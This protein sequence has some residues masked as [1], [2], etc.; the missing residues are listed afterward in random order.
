VYRAGG[1]R[2][3]T[4]GALVTLAA[5]AIAGG[6]AFAYLVARRYGTPFVVAKKIGIGGLVFI[7]GRLAI[8][9]VHESAHALAMASYG[10]RVSAAGLKLVLVFPYAFVDTSDVWFESR[11]HRIA[12]TAAGPASDFALGGLF[13]LIAFALAPGT[14]RDVVFQLAFAAYVGAV[15]NLNPFLDRDG[16]QILVDVLRRPRLR[17]AAAE[18]LKRRL[19]GGEAGPDSALL[20][21]Y[22]AFRVGWLGLA[23][24]YSVAMSLHY[25]ARFAALVPT[26]VA[27]T[28]MAVLWVAFF[29]PVAVAAMP[30]WRARR[31]GGSG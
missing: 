28:A 13:S 4:R 25:Q 8:A 19:S 6:M 21:R 17:K 23:G 29:A 15:F 14:L 9:A 20:A 30:L 2:L 18:E 24:L 27:W 26:P 31:L 22:S 11:R 3:F 1:W 5:L 10:R 16:Y 12:V 7:L